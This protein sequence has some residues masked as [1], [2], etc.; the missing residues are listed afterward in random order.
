MLPVMGSFTG[1]AMLAVFDTVPAAT[2]AALTVPTM[3]IVPMPPGEDGMI[4]LRVQVTRRVPASKPH[5]QAAVVEP[6]ET[7]SMPAGSGSVT[8]T[9]VGACPP[10]YEGDRV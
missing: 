2:P 10:T 9:A 3:V 4:V 8:V 7:K 6:A 1:V 5:T